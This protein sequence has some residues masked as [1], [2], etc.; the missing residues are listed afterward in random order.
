[1]Q[2]SAKEKA[3]EVK[4]IETYSNFSFNDIHWYGP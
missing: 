3:L 2:K 4:A 1:M